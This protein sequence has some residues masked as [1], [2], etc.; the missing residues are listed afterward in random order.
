[1]GAVACCIGNSAE[2]VPPC[3]F[4]P[5]QLLLSLLG[6]TLYSRKEKKESGRGLSFSFRSHTRFSESLSRRL[7]TFSEGQVR[8]KKSYFFSE[9][10]GSPESGVRVPLTQNARQRSRSR[11]Q[12]QSMI[13]AAMRAAS[14]VLA[15]FLPVLDRCRV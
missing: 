9:D 13:D 1:M 10:G 8:E 14:I 4:L 7:L 11:R 3:R 2:T 12:S 5:L 6:L 15:D